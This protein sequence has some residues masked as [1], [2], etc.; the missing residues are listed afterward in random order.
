MDCNR[1]WPQ[2]ELFVPIGSLR[3]QSSS[4]DGSNTGS[5]VST[6][7]TT[8]LQQQNQPRD[9]YRFFLR[10]FGLFWP[11]ISDTAVNFVMDSEEYSKA[12][13]NADGSKDTDIH[14]VVDYVK[15]HRQLK[16]E[17]PT[18]TNIASTTSNDQVD[19][20]FHAGTGA[21]RTRQIHYKFSLTDSRAYSGPREP[22]KQE[23]LM[24]WADNF[25]SAEY[26]GFVGTDT[27][28][29]TYVDRE[30]LFE[31]GKPL[32]NGRYSGYVLD[33]SCPLFG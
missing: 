14:V 19:F 26:V 23:Y 7:S 17:T 8:F 32:V 33:D 3:T 25:T 31:N 30:D 20:S 13:T 24:F 4:S 15:A 6:S 12:R 28:F 16:A 27:V 10:S 9:V 18:V 22:H 29:L 21:L 2:L 5:S 11:S 1:L